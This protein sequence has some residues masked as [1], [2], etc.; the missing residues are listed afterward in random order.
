MILKPLSSSTLEGV[1]PWRE[2][3]FKDLSSISSLLVVV[4]LVVVVV[5]I[6]VVVGAAAVVE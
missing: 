4:V 1:L 2:R 3:Y 6:V 5:V